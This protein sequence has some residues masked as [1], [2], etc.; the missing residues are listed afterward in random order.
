MLY[1]TLM[2][3]VFALIAGVLGFTGIRDSGCGHRKTAVCDFSGVL[4]DFAR[5]PYIASRQRSLEFVPSVRRL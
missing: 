4:S 2:F 3:L 5:D 1:W